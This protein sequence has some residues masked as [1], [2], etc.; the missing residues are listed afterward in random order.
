MHAFLQ[1]ETGHIVEE[2]NKMFMHKG[3]DFRLLHISFA[4]L[5]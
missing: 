4:R 5:R 1:Q 2:Q 3:E